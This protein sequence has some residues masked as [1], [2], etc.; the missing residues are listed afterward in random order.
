MI[1]TGPEII[2]M[3]QSG[4]IVITPFDKQ[5]VNPNSYNMRLDKTLLIYKNHKRFLDAKLDNPTI[6]IEIPEDGMI[7]YPG[8]L[9]LGQSMEYTETYNLVPLVEGRSS[10]GR[11]GLFVHVTAGVGDNGF[12][13]TWTLEMCVVQP[14]KIY[15]GMEICQILY[16]SIFGKPMLYQG[17]YQNA[18]KVESSRMYKELGK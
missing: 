14:V 2:K 5:R 17:K 8:T 16:H 3:R 9:Y 12:R 11:L 7:L 10:I 4:H 18:R 15:A 6:V 1:L 13:G